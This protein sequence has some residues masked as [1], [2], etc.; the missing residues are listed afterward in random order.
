VTLAGACGSA[1]PGRT[2]QTTTTERTPASGIIPIVAAGLGT[3]TC[4]TP[5]STPRWGIT[6]D[7]NGT[8]TVTEDPL[9]TTTEQGR[10]TLDATG[11]HARVDSPFPFTLNVLSPAL[12]GPDGL[13]VTTATLVA[14][15]PVKS[16]TGT[17][18]KTITE[19]LHISRHGVN[20]MS[21]R[22]DHEGTGTPTVTW[23]CQRQ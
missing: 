16:I 6:V 2:S 20:Q 13:G 21:F 3:W 7:D 10:W 22:A 9:S 17:P 1:T 8:F 4:S 12:E 5:T 23:T 19:T 11:L 15:S 18:I 14:A